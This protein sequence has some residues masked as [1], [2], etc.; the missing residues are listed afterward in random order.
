M[1]WVTTATGLHCTTHG[2]SFRPPAA[3][4]APDGKP[5]DCDEDE[6]EERGAMEAVQDAAE[7]A[8]L[9]DRIEAERAFWNGCTRVNGWIGE[10]EESAREC[11]D[12]K[13]LWLQHMTLLAKLKDVA[14]KDARS[15]VELLTHRERMSEAERRERAIRAHHTPKGR[16]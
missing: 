12:D 10:V 2:A 15:A 7:S 5:C 4:P 11:R 13:P 14:S 3:C 16:H 8:G 6:V 9:P 1:P